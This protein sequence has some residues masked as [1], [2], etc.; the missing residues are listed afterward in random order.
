M[1]VGPEQREEPAPLGVLS[2]PPGQGSARKSSAGPRA[3]AALRPRSGAG[4]SPGG[5]AAEAESGHPEGS[6]VL[7]PL[8]WDSDNPLSAGPQPGFL[9]AENSEAA[10]IS[11]GSPVPS[12]LI[13]Q[14]PPELLPSS[15]K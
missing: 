4:P 5:G 14:Q 11:Q 10:P 6:A 1:G 13:S 8:L 7:R 3:G 15:H 12:P 9:G 2:Q